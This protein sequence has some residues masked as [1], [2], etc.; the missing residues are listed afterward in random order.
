[1]GAEAVK[2]SGKTTGFYRGSGKNDYPSSRWSVGSG[3]DCCGNPLRTRSKRRSP[4][5]GAGVTPGSIVGLLLLLFGLYLPLSLYLSCFIC[6]MIWTT[7]LVHSW[8]W[9]WPL[10]HISCNVDCLNTIF[11]FLFLSYWLQQDR[12][13]TGSGSYGTSGN[14]N[15]SSGNRTGSGTTYQSRAKL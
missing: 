13:G 9:P 14:G 10:L 8:W 6:S 12:D 15:D 5:I 2:F 11:N 7:Y 1:M 4:F 3:T